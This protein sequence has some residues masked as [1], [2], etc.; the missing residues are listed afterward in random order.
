MVR[1]AARN[2]VAWYVAGATTVVKLMMPAATLTQVRLAS[3]TPA[4]TSSTG[5]A[6]T[7]TTSRFLLVA[8]GT[9]LHELAKY[10]VLLA[11][12]LLGRLLLLGE[13]LT[14]IR[15]APVHLCDELEDGQSVVMM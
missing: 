5:W 6:A 11:P 7:T 14:C 8:R 15:V 12:N 4:L 13:R 9:I 10:V 2:T 3:C 1:A